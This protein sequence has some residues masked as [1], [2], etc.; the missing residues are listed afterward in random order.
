VGLI[1]QR[2]DS[3]RWF[4][5]VFVLLVTLACSHVTYLLRRVALSLDPPA[6]F[7]GWLDGISGRLI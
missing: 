6:E 5:A 1:R 4:G 3:V 7:D 2:A